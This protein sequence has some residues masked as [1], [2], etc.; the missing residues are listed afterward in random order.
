MSQEE[1]VTWRFTDIK[2]NYTHAG[3]STQDAK[4]PDEAESDEAVWP[5]GPMCE[6][7]SDG[8]SGRRRQITEGPDD[9][10]NGLNTVRAF[11]FLDCGVGTSHWSHHCL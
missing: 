11:L 6:L 3:L 1:L 4:R 5:C 2:T 7:S 10:A 9:R 8:S